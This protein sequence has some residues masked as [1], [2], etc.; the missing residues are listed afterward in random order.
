MPKYRTNF[1]D[2]V[3]LRIDFEDISLLKLDEY[4]DIIKRVFD[5]SNFQNGFTGSFNIDVAQGVV[6][7]S[8]QELSI[9]EFNSSTKVNKKISLSQKWINLEYNTHSYTNSTELLEDVESFIV[10]FIETLE[11]RLINRIGLR[12]INQ[13]V[14]PENVNPLVWSTYINSG[15]VGSLAFA[16]RRNFPISRNFTQ[17]YYKLPNAD[18]VFSFGLWNEDFPNPIIT[19]TFVLDYDCF[20]TLPRGVNDI[21]LRTEVKSYN[22]I[23]EKFFE[24]SIKQPL[25]ELMGVED[26]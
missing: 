3:I 1:L 23:V 26:E 13:I 2:K 8:R 5:V 9:K 14:A 4:S 25:R 18:V 12:Y 24:D 6:T 22:E 17:Q 10:P 7:Q 11:V 20:S 21:T 16:R 15:L 19:K